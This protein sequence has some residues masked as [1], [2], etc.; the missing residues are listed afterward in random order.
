MGLLD[1][2]VGFNAT[3]C[4]R[5]AGV[6]FYFFASVNFHRFG[7]QRFCC[8]S[9]SLGSMQGRLRT[10]LCEMSRG[11]A[12][13]QSP[14]SNLRFCL[15]GVSLPS[16][17]SFSAISGLLV[18]LP[19]KLDGEFAGWGK[20]PEDE[21]VGLVIIHSPRAVLEIAEVL[22][23]CK[24]SYH[25]TYSRY[26]LSVI[27]DNYCLPRHARSASYLCGIRLSNRGFLIRLHQQTQDFA[28]VTIVIIYI[29]ESS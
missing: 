12:D 1:C 22:Y 7:F 5:G 18:F 29:I 2:T 27:A 11:S 6:A 26:P 17:L 14:L 8:Y 16:L 21:V 15:S 24:L 13:M 23:R 4:L 19:F 10:L 3:P 9:A 20:L 25:C 28:I